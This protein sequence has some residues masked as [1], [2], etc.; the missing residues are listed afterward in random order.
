VPRPCRYR[1][2][3]GILLDGHSDRGTCNVSPGTRGD[4][5]LF[6]EV[7][8]HGRQDEGHAECLTGVDLPLQCG[9]NVVL[10]HELVARRALELGTEFVQQRLSGGTLKTLTS[11]ALTA[12]EK[13][14]LS[15]WPREQ[16]R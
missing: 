16:S 6:E 13:S 9:G 14:Q 3:R 7:V 8:D 11:A 15:H 1:G 5:A 12:P 2:L 4:L 10:D